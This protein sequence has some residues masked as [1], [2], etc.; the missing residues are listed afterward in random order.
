M[1]R[2]R[3]LLPALLLFSFLA[4]A[5]RSPVKKALASS[6]AVSEK[7][8]AIQF[9]NPDFVVRRLNIPANESSSVAASVHD[10]VLV[11]YGQNS[12]VCSG[13]QTNFEM[14]MGDGEIQVLQG[15]WPHTIKNGTQASSNLLA[16]E[17]VRNIEPKTAL[18]GLG[19]KNCSQTRFGKSAQGE[20]QQALLFETDTTALYRAQLG[21]GVSMHQ[22]GDNRRHLI[23]ALTPLD[24]HIGDA[25]FSLKPGETYFVP[26][27]F[28]DIGN[29]TAT[30]ATM[31]ILELK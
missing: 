23:I 20:Y 3:L 8:S 6:N 12:V 10:Y 29:D 11:S 31:L 26:S 14:N 19:A 22:H 2:L 16:I 7:F 4:V 21:S 30:P 28:E 17:V 9:R 13:Y 27:G 1:S 15:G 5:Q 24:A 25:T 18:C